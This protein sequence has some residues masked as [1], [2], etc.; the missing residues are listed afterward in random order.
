MDRNIQ[1]IS[2]AWSST[3]LSDDL[4][5][6]CCLLPSPRKLHLSHWEPPAWIRE[7]WSRIDRDP[8]SRTCLKWMHCLKSTIASTE[9]IGSCRYQPTDRLPPCSYQYYMLKETQSHT[10]T[11]TEHPVNDR[12]AKQRQLALW[13]STNQH[14]NKH[15]LSTVLVRSTRSSPIHHFMFSKVPGRARE[16]LK[17]LPS[18]QESKC[19]CHRIWQPTW[20]LWDTRE[21]HRL[22]PSSVNDSQITWGVDSSTSH[23]LPLLLLPSASNSTFHWTASPP[24]PV[25]DVCECSPGPLSV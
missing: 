23:A 25:C 9:R 22:A 10:P 13:Y 16:W 24:Y 1:T 15:K 20:R 7:V 5:C 4:C 2:P 3:C 14:R 17:A 18:L 12:S 11:W 19:I 21:S 8:K 6:I